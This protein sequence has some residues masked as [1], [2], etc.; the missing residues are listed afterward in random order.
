MGA[1]GGGKRGTRTSSTPAPCAPHLGA[2]AFSPR[3]I[4]STPQLSSSVHRH[5]GSAV[6]IRAPTRCP[7]CT[8][9]SHH[10]F[11]M[12]STW[13]RQPESVLCRVALRGLLGQGPP[14]PAAPPRPRGDCKVPVS[15]VW[16]SHL[17]P[18]PLLGPTSLQTLRHTDPQGGTCCL[19]IPAQLPGQLCSPSLLSLHTPPIPVWGQHM[20]GQYPQPPCPLAQALRGKSKPRP[21]SPDHPRAPG[22]IQ[23][24]G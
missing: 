18:W 19:P 14:C 7:P 13:C 21:L 12:G 3:S 17:A 1:L 11:S 16:P 22:P 4:S 20:A 23:L 6:Q 2:S 8:P 15:S 10:P 5:G 9:H 24:T